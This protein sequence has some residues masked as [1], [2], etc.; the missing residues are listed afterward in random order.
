MRLEVYAW[1]AQN[2]RMAL[3]GIRSMNRT[4][5]SAR[6]M[7]NLI[8]EIAV[9]RDQNSCCCRF[10]KRRR[11]RCKCTAILNER[12]THGRFPTWKCSTHGKA[13]WNGKAKRN[14]ARKAGTIGSACPVACQTAIHI[15]P[16]ETEAEAINDARES[17]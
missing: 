14:P 7:L 13:N 1:A 11:N 17:E 3:N 8:D 2:L 10:G 4:D 6:A 9:P 5:D 12:T 15:G 16:F